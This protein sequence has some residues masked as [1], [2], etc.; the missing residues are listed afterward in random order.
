M[1]GSET[2]DPGG[3]ATYEATWEDPPPGEYTAVATLEAREHDCEARA[4]FSVP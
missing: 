3:T 4:E 2:V 1:L